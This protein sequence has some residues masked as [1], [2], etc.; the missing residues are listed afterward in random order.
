MDI[1]K[2]LELLQDATS[3]AVD[4]LDIEFDLLANRYDRLTQEI[5]WW[6]RFM[7]YCHTGK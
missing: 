5:Q 7:T 1:T 4:Q 6:E 3:L 2:V